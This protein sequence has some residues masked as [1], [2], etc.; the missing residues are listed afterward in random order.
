MRI[1]S[2]KSR[3]LPSQPPASG[4]ELGEPLQQSGRTCVRYRGRKL[5]YFGGCDY[6]RLS[7][8]PAMLRAIGEGL[9]RYGLNVA[10]SR[11]TTGNHPLYEQLEASLAE[12]FGAE[13]AVLV[14]SGYLTGQ[15]AAQALAGQFSHVLVDERAH[16]CLSDAARILDCP[17]LK[18]QHRTVAAAA[19]AARQ[20]GPQARLLLITDGLFAH[21]GQVAPLDLYLRRLPRRTWFL[22]DDAHAAGVLGRRGRGT[23]EHLGVPTDRIVQ[24]VTLSKAFGGYGGAV[25]GPKAVR[26]A[27]IARSRTFTGNTPLPLPLAF[28]ATRALTLLA[29]GTGLRDRLARN[30]HQVKT[31]L[32]QAGFANLDGCGPIVSLVPATTTELDQLK[33]RLLKHGIYPSHIRYPGGPAIGYF[34]FAISS[35]HTRTQLDAL[36]GALIDG[37]PSGEART[38]GGL[39]NRAKPK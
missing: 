35:E 6:F 28:A 19:A 32:R 11:T 24:T 16:A 8:H 9:R 1:Q 36:V 25:L 29:P 31:A 13:S 7:S 38:G 37:H 34:R 14:S 21:D 15:V 4:C 10:A 2:R 5:V 27:V 17:I 26:D 3:S 18:F 12:F 22:V 39:R 23:A 33:S 30:V 20:C